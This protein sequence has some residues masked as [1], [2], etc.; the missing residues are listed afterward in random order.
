MYL[1]LSN[2]HAC[3]NITCIVDIILA[4]VTPAIGFFCSGGRCLLVSIKHNA[5]IVAKVV[6]PLGTVVTV[7]NDQEELSN[8]EPVDDAIIHENCDEA[9]F[10]PVVGARPIIHPKITT[11]EETK[12]DKNV[13]ETQ[14]YQGLKSEEIVKMNNPP[15]KTNKKN[16]KSKQKQQIKESPTVIEQLP[17]K[18]LC[19]SLEKILFSEDKDEPKDD[20]REM[21]SSVEKLLPEHPTKTIE[22]DQTK[23]MWSSIEHC[24]M[25]E[26]TFLAMTSSCTDAESELK[27]TILGSE[28][29][30]IEKSDD[31]LMPNN[32][33]SETTESDDSA[34][35]KTLVSVAD[36]TTEDNTANSMPNAPA[37]SSQK[38]SKKKAKKKRK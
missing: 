5:H 29:I 18:E 23:E 14:R 26:S 21:W 32:N 22:D 17:V 1:Y 38:N 28:T 3:M 19:N 13:T 9:L 15:E 36:Y 25:D 20:T 12:N 35:N 16:K 33:S 6:N 8:E 27:P 10:R 2:E 7:P 34:K 11:Q 31:D 24:K 37:Q 4:A 30:K